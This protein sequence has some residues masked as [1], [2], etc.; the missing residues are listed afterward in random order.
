MR[1]YKTAGWHHVC[2]RVQSVDAAI[3]QLKQRDVIVVSEPHDVLPM[4][5]R[6]A[7]FADPWGN[8]FELTQTLDNRS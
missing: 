1:S 5:L 4:G 7:F 8:L 6:L 3:E 2:F